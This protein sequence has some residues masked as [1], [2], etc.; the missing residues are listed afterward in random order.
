MAQLKALS[1]IEEII[2]SFEL[3]LEIWKT[4]INLM[5]STLHAS[6]N[7]LTSTNIGTRS[8]NRVLD[9]NPG[10]AISLWR[11]LCQN[12]WMVSYLCLINS[13]ICEMRRV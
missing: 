8:K 2:S 7:M 11:G 3:E 6:L 4:S 5:F 9:S 10:I 12:T 1:I 13:F